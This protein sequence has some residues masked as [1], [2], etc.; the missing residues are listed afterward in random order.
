MKK[1]YFFLHSWFD[2][3]NSLNSW[4]KTCEIYVIKYSVHGHRVRTLFYVTNYKNCE[5]AEFLGDMLTMLCNNG[6]SW[7][8]AVLRKHVNWGEKKCYLDTASL[9]ARYISTTTEWP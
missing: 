3:F 2:S 1:M 4:G 6:A 8:S 9:A 5:D 7:T